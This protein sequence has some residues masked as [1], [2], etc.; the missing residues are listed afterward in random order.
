MG[1]KTLTLFL[2]APPYAGQ[3]ASTAMR[4]AKAALEAG[5]QVNL[6]ASGDGVYVFTT[7]HRPKGIPDVEA[8][9][10]ALVAQGQHVELC[11]SCLTVRGLKREQL[12]PG[13]EP[14]SMPGLFRLVRASDVVL[15][16]GS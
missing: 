7:G 8:G 5:H 13:A 3:A 15:T 2:S 12:L 4:L 16:L 11:G 6:F 1:R 10:R 9:F 14:S